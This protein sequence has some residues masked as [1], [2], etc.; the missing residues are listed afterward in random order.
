MVNT[1]LW[2]VAIFLKTFSVFFFFV[3]GIASFNPNEAEGGY[4]K[5]AELPPQVTLFFAPKSPL[6]PI[7]LCF[8]IS[9]PLEVQG[10][11]Y[12][13]PNAPTTTGSILRVVLANSDQVVLSL[14]EMWS[15]TNP[16]KWK[17]GCS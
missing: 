12:R 10:W 14:G 5:T 1:L 17:V 2:L 9:V 13:D 7:A 11:L 6:T 4:I 3:L 16:S 15:A 8:Q